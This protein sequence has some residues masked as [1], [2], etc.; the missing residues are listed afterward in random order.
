MLPL[1][2]PL[3]KASAVEAAIL[4]GV[5]GTRTLS[6]T[7][8]TPTVG[9]SSSQ[10]APP[11]T[12]L[13]TSSDEG[14]DVLLPFDAATYVPRIHIIGRGGS[15]RYRPPLSDAPPKVLYREPEQ[16]LSYTNIKVNF[17]LQN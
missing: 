9:G 5:S 6:S 16:H 13:K 1:P 3:C 17:L 2:P 11:E 8:C 12:E 10:P 4:S 15:L 14:D 7:L